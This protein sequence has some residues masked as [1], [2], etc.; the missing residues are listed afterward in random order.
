MAFILGYID[1]CKDGDLEYSAKVVEGLLHL[2][3]MTITWD[4]IRVKLEQ[5]LKS[6]GMSKPSVSKLMDRGIGYI[7]I[8][9]LPADVRSELHGLRQEWGL[10]PLHLGNDSS[11]YPVTNTLHA[12]VDE[13]VSVHMIL[14]TSLPSTRRHP[15][16]RNPLRHEQM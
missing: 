3:S 10:P 9:V 12:V 14:V 4:T 5:S 2:S 8:E 13:D 6:Y 7:D 16:L 11:A 1:F 15:A